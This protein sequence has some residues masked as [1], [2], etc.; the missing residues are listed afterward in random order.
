[1]A[2]KHLG[3]TKKA[4]VGSPRPDRRRRAG[5]ASHAARNPIDNAGR[6]IR[7]ET[8][9]AQNIAEGVY[10]V[11]ASDLRIVY[12]NRRME[13]IFGYG[14]GEL[15]GQPVAIL[16]AP[17]GADA[18]KTARRHRRERSSRLV[19]GAAKCSTS[20]RT[21][22]RSGDT[23]R[24]PRRTTPGSATSTS[25]CKRISRSTSGRTKRCG[26]A[27]NGSA[28]LPNR[29]PTSSTPPTRGAPSRLS[30]RPAHAPLASRRT[31][32]AAIRSPTFSSRRKF[33]RPSAP[34]PRRS[35]PASPRTISN[36]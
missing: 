1:M 4:S 10:L 36:Y 22:R 12:A 14:P 29:W 5:S 8:V 2:S 31:R 20:G 27:R 32:C 30:R 11:S 18:E 7:I 25:R 35:A 19:R 33:R 24:S 13:A 9:I 26:K 34:L 15:I 17:A 6:A 28:R 16:N 23:R 21:E 3:L